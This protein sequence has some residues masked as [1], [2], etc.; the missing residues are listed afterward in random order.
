MSPFKY[1]LGKIL[2]I[3]PILKGSC[4]ACHNSDPNALVSNMPLAT[5]DDV[6][7]YTEPGL[8]ARR[9]A[10]QMHYHLFGIGTF[11]LIITILFRLLAQMLAL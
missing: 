7:E 10:A 6:M 2:N 5:Y 11:L 3:K 9:L 4:V 8:S 1:R